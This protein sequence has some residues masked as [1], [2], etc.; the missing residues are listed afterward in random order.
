MKKSI[1]RGKDRSN[2]R[3]VSLGQKGRLA[4]HVFLMPPAGLLRW[5]QRVNRLEGHCQWK[6]PPALLTNRASDAEISKDVKASEIRI[7]PRFVLQ[8][9]QP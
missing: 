8:S 9:L 5:M 7:D 4:G 2:I 3:L 1:A 6:W